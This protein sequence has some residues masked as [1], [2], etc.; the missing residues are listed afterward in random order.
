MIFDQDEKPHF[1]VHSNIII[2]NGKLTNPKGLVYQ[3]WHQIIRRILP[4]IKKVRMYNI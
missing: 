2:D 3:N 4:H 1:S